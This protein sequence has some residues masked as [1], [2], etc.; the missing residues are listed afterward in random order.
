MPKYNH[1]DIFYLQSL[2]NR[3]RGLFIVLRRYEDI[4]FYIPAVD[5]TNVMRIGSQE[6]FE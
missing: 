6:E 2:K 5:T 4:T 1:I 3:V